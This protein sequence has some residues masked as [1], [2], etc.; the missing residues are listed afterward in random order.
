MLELGPYGSVRGA[1][2]N[3]RPYRDPGPKAD[4]S[5]IQGKGDFFTG[6]CRALA[7]RNISSPPLD[8]IAWALLRVLCQKT[9]S[10]R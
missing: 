3:S 2:G 4:V 1:R 9:T 10:Y 6:Y 8:A 7:F 5:M